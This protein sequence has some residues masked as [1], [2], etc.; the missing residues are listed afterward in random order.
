M[1]LTLGLHPTPHNPAAL[2]SAWRKRNTTLFYKQN[3]YNLLRE[4]SEGFSGLIVLLTGTDALDISPLDEP[5]DVRR[6]RAKRVWGKVMALI[7]YFNL[8]PPRVLD[9]ILE[10]AS[11]HVASHWRFFLDLLKC[12][13][14]GSSAREPTR[15]GKERAHDWMQAEME[16]ISG[17]MTPGGD[18]VL[19]QVLGVK[20]GFYQVRVSCDVRSDRRD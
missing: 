12:S 4:S 16:A 20:F 10:V 1:L 13:P 14:W 19:A 8:S 11:C 3:K 17:S 2:Q 6:S 15:K 18:R 9:V 5:E 7:G